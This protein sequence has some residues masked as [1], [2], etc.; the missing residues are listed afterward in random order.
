VITTALR[1]TEEETGVSP[2]NI[3]VD[4]DF[5]FVTEYQVT[6]KSR[7]N[8]LKRVTYFIGYLNQ[9]C[10]ISLSEHIDYRWWTWPPPNSI[11]S[12]TIDP[13]LQAASTHFQLHPQRLRPAGPSE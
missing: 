10:E 12:Q 5:C 9:T 7:G 6:G 3:E 11:Q 1:E 2:T 8:Y 4:P 13:L